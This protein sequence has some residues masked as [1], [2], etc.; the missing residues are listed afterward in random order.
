ATGEDL[1][2]GLQQL[3]VLLVVV[4]DED[5]RLAEV[6]GLALG[7]GFGAGVLNAHTVPGV[8][9]SGLFTGGQFVHGRVSQAP[10]N[11]S[12]SRSRA[13][14]KASAG[15]V[16][17]RCRRASRSAGSSTAVQRG[18]ADTDSPARRAAARV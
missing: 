6:E 1:E 17:S 3:D 12:R 16:A 11:R 2:V 4:D 9:G 7:G 14:S 10:R 8:G 13:G 5:G 18:N 15:G